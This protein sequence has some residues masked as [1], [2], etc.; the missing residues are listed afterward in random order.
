MKKWILSAVAIVAAATAAVA[1]IP[2]ESFEKWDSVETVELP[3]GWY[4]GQ[5]GSG[6]VES[7]H[8]GRYAAS[9]WNWY[10]YAK[11]YLIT[12]PRGTWFVDLAAAGVPID[13]KPTKLTG[14]YRYD[15]GRN[16]R[17]NDSAVAYVMLKR[18]NPETGKRDTIGF[19]KKLLGPA[20]AYTPFTVD[21]RDYAPGILPDSITLAFVSSD[22]G[23]CEGESDGNC[24]YLSI[25]DIQLSLSSGVSYDARPLFD[26]ARVYPT[27]LRSSGRIEWSARAGTSY[28]LRLYS[29]SGA[30]V[31][32][33]DGLTGGSARID[34]AGLPSGEYLFEIRHGDGVAGR[35]RVV[36]E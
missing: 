33:V 10:Y 25:D 34:R 9:V 3:P 17:K 28:T 21:I 29:V 18:Y 2:Q 27:P 36:V 31:R 32:T 16:Q 12:G 8:S 5:F 23:F 26:A 24:C 22:S 4:G 15:L 14:Y 6:K 11:G 30:L 13:Y 35:G 1:Q 19:A 20:A 7:A